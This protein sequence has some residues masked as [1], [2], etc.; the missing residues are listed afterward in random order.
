MLARLHEMVLRAVLQAGPDCRAAEVQEIVG[1]FI[2]REASFGSIFTTLDRVGDKGM[3]TY[4]KG[5]P[6]TRR[7]GRSPR[8]YT[9]TEAGAAALAEATRLAEAMQGSGKAAGSALHPTG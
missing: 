6:D 4:R 5:E 1:G 2:G 7:G 8:L 9:L 3:V